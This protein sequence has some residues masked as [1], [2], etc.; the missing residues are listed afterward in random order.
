MELIEILTNCRKLAKFVSEYSLGNIKRQADSL[1]KRIDKYIEDEKI[2][3]QVD[4]N[5]S[6]NIS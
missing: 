2:Y 3:G 6:N 1:I 4:N 5:S